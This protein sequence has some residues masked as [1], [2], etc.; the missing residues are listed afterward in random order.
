MDL[1][2]ETIHTWIDENT[3]EATGKNYKSRTNY[4]FKMIDGNVLD[5]IKSKEVLKIILERGGSAS[6]IKGAVQVFLKLIKEYPGLLDAVGEKIYNTYN[7]FFLEANAEMSSGYIQKAI[8]KDEE[9]AIEPFTELKKKVYE[10]FNEGSDQRL[11]MDL[12]EIAPVRDNFGRL[13]I[14]PKVADA[15][16]KTKN[17]YV[18]SN[19]QLIINHHKSQNKYGTLKYKIPKPVWKKIHLGRPY[20]F[21]RAES[22]SPFVGD[23]LKA[24]GVEGAINTLRHSYLSEQLDGEKIKDPQIR[25]ELFQRMA[26]SQSAQL[27]YIRALKKDE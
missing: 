1:T 25:K 26:H 22:L 5:A 27:G 9:D 21:N 4:I 18:I 19:H 17:Y 14:V 24:I 15:K 3:S 12:Y 11:Y 10:K 6:T 8:D 23:M 20:V 13:L 7:K 2:K 16:D